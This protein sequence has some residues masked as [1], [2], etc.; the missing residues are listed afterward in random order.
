MCYLL[1]N[2]H[3][4]SNTLYSA[5]SKVT[6]VWLRFNKMLCNC[7]QYHS[8]KVK[9]FAAKLRA[10]ASEYAESQGLTLR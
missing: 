1:P 7:E 6:T 3:K 10:Y 5:H 8:D 4:T 9:K 2:Y